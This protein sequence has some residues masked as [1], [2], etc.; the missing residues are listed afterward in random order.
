SETIQLEFYLDDRLLIGRASANAPRRDLEALLTNTAH[1][2]EFL[3]PLAYC[4][5]ARRSITIRESRQREMSL[6]DGREGRT[7]AEV[8]F[9]YR[10]DQGLSAALLATDRL[11]EIARQLERLRGE[12]SFVR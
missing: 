3:V 7:L 6:K 10:H 1:G 4:D 5:G 2:F 9:A 12:L 11:D 8:T